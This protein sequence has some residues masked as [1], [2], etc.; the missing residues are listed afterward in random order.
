MK[1]NPPLL[2]GHGAIVTELK[3]TKTENGQLKQKVE[4][5]EKEKFLLK[6]KLEQTEAKLKAALEK[7]EEKTKD[8]VWIHGHL[9]T[10]R[11]WLIRWKLNSSFI[12]TFK[13]TQVSKG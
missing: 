1:L 6:Q 11:G 4:T 12:R 13:R 10:S 2:S 9:A 7:A 8:K 3:A 5:L